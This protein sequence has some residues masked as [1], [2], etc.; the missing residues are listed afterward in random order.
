MRSIGRVN[1]VWRIRR[2]EVVQNC[3]IPV[4]TLVMIVTI[5]YPEWLMGWWYLT[6]ALSRKISEGLTRSRTSDM[7]RTM[8][9]RNVFRKKC[10]V[11][12]P[13]EGRPGGGEEA[14]V[15]YLG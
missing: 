9:S 15:R 11:A 1:A 2:N 12:A 14:V 13:R 8:P 6:S 5:V 3:A 7:S 4:A 10:A